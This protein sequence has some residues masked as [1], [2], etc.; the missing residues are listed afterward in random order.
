M[1]LIPQI[2][3]ELGDKYSIQL[4]TGFSRSDKEIKPLV[5]IRVIWE[6]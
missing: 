2:H 4:G 5:A 1:A 3:Y 6:L